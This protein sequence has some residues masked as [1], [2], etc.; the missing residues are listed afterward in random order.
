MFFI[1]IR[2][3]DVYTTSIKVSVWTLQSLSHQLHYAIFTWP[4]AVQGLSVY[5]SSVL[6][7]TAGS[8]FSEVDILEIVATPRV[9]CVP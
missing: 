6:R 3:K 1:L 5:T 7:P 8:I 4:M 2:I 9:Y